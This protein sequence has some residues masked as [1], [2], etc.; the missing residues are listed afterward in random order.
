MAGKQYVTVRDK[1]GKRK[2]QKRALTMWQRPIA[3][4]LE[5]IPQ[6]LLGKVNL[7]NYDWQSSYYHQKCPATFV[8]AFTMPT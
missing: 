6:S 3:C 7:Q 4:L 5:K 8:A 1:N 2:E